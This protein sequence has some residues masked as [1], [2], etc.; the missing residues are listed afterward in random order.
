M[1]TITLPT[2]MKANYFTV[3]IP[4][5]LPSPVKCTLCHNFNHRTNSRKEPIRSNFGEANLV[6]PYLPTVL[7]TMGPY[8]HDR[9]CPE[10]LSHRELLFAYMIN[11][12]QIIL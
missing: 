4:P 8:C 10:R 2:K 11:L 9:N 12:L 6:A 5:Y 7:I 1:V 3:P